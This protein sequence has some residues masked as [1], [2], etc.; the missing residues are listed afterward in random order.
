MNIKTTAYFKGKAVE[1]EFSDPDELEELLTRPGWTREPT[2]VEPLDERFADGRQLH[3]IGA[4]PYLKSNGEPAI[5]LYDDDDTLGDGTPKKYSDCIVWKEQWDKF[6]PFLDGFDIDSVS[7]QQLQRQPAMR[8][9]YWQPLDIIVVQMPKRNKAGEIVTKADGVNPVWVYDHIQGTK[10]TEEDE[11]E[12]KETVLDGWKES[13]RKDAKSAWAWTN[14]YI[15][16]GQLDEDVAKAKWRE[17]TE[18]LGGGNKVAAIWFEEV[19]ELL[20]SDDDEVPF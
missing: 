11:L 14:R 17:L 15:L 4:V 2:A 7:P 6:V 20:S 1:V 10:V 19:M 16:S 13:Y 18:K 9:E 5:A 12:I 8:S 3:I